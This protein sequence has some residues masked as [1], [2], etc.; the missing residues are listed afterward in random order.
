MQAEARIAELRRALHA[1]NHRYYVLSEPVISDREFDLLLAELE[2]LESKHP[3][4]ADDNS[5]TKRVG[6]GLSDQ[7]EKV[8]HSRPMLSLSNS[9]NADEL[10]EWADRVQKETAGDCRFT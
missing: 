6:S 2:T 3:E 9:Y 8:A 4:F 7:F 5:P 10:Q 1:H